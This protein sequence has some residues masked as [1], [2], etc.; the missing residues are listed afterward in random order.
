MRNEEAVLNGLPAARQG[1]MRNEG[2]MQMTVHTPVHVAASPVLTNGTGTSPASETPA[3][4]AT[5]ATAVATMLSVDVKMDS[6][7]EP[8][9]SPG[10][11][12]ISGEDN[13]S[14]THQGLW[15][16]HV[17]TAEEDDKLLD[18]INNCGSKV[19]WSVVGLQMD[20]RSGKQ[21]RERWHNH[22]SPDVHKAKWSADE[23]RA[24]VEAVQFYGTRWSEIVKMFPGRTDNAIKNRWNSML[25]K[26]ERRRK[27]VHE[28]LHPPETGT[29]SEL[30]WR[31]RRLAQPSSLQ[32]VAALRLP[33]EMGSGPAVGSALM[34]QLQEVGVAPPCVK[35]GGRRKRAVQAR[36]D[37]DA[38]SLFLGT[39]SKIQHEN[40]PAVVPTRPTEMFDSTAV[41]A[42]PCASSCATVVSAAVTAT[43]FSPTAAPSPISAMPRFPPAKEECEQS[44]PYQNVPTMHD[45]ETD[46]ALVP[47]ETPASTPNVSLTPSSTVSAATIGVVDSSAPCPKER[48]LLK[49]QETEYPGDKENK[50]LASEALWRI[51]AGARGASPAPSTLG[52]LSPTADSPCRKAALLSR[53][54]DCRWSVEHEGFK[55][56]EAAIAIQALQNSMP[57]RPTAPAF[58]AKA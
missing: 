16:K 17:W 41:A 3:S 1:A 2:P 4:Q 33:V 48:V 50:T 26:E 32:P 56:I 14:P 49:R 11:E 13:S 58:A 5:P 28:E 15:K 38:A 7:V 10:S 47:A 37:M 23:D 22:L 12:S 27:R 44:L 55:S 43:V 6:E 40:S 20:G 31:R 8:E 35:P 45:I 46:A 9:P 21:C 36:V 51:S 25:R 52:V 57:Q 30:K 19:R 54:S 42:T 34:Q 39:I 18:L 29:E 53:A 24:I